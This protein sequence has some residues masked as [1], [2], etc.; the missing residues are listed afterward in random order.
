MNAE[1]R[2]TSRTATCFYEGFVRH[3]R[4]T[5]VEHAFRYRL[6]LV[7]LNLDDI[8]SM[9]GKRGFWSTRWPCAARFNRRDHLGNPELPLGD[10]VRSL[11]E[12][13][14]GWRPTGPICLLTSLR[15]FGFLM[16]PVSFYYCFD[17]SGQTVQ[18]V[19]AEVT[20]TP[21]RQQHCYV[22]DT[23][24]QES[25]TLTSRHPK[26]FHVSP[27][28]EMEMDYDWRISVPGR[29]LAVR[30]D[31]RTESGS[32]FDAMLWLRRRPFTT[33]WKIWLLIR[34]PLMTLQILAGIYWQALRLWLK[35][36]P[37][38]PHPGPTL[39]RPEVDQNHIISPTK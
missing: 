28:L 1:K 4:R 2:M 37:Y 21:W 26:A 19:V 11:V 13:R 35:R 31:N 25:G 20:N 29:H 36:V 6:F 15:Y 34:Y 7:Y 32:P 14:L 39:I 22:L 16:N 8:Q 3:R 17:Q 24:V 12:S 33:G 5:P 18:A 38:V 23:K 9:L 10:C 30:I 27:F